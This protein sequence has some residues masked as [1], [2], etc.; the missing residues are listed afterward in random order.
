MLSL[1]AHS[2]IFNNSFCLKVFK[3]SLPAKEVFKI[4][5]LRI[6]TKAP[7]QNNDDQ[8]DDTAVKAVA[9]FVGNRVMDAVSLQRRKSAIVASMAMCRPAKPLKVVFDAL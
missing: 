2:G 4:L 6:W 9:P 7:I 1:P 8:S 5:G 3:S